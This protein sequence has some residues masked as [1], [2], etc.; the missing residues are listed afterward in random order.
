MPKS[1]LV[2]AEPA[3]SLA[4]ATGLVSAVLTV[5]VTH[6]VITDT[7]ASSTTQAVV[8][9]VALLLPMLGGA[10]VRRLVAPMTKVGDVLEQAGLLT[11]ADW[12]RLE[13]VIEDKLGI[14]L[15][16]VDTGDEHPDAVD[17]GEPADGMAAGADPDMHV[18]EH[19][20]PTPEGA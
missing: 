18:P 11:D 5:L 1:D 2:K 6:G 12:A 7:A 14:D 20:R 8:P 13:G 16:G 4:T 19:A 10:V 3:M 17:I 15:D 9:F